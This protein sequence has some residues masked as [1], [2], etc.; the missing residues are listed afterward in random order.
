MNLMQA[1]KKNHDSRVNAELRINI[2]EM[3]QAFKN[4][5]IQREKM[6]AMGMHPYN[7]LGDLDEA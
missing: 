5:E 3:R 1:I 7:L 2:R 4:I 6:R